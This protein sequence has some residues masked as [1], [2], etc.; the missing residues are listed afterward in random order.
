MRT[1]SSILGCL[2]R[3]HWPGSVTMPDGRMQVAWTWEHYKY[4]PDPQGTT[5]DGLEDCQA[6]VLHDFWVSFFDIFVIW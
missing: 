4:A 3:H 5:E 1:Y 2:V 6:R